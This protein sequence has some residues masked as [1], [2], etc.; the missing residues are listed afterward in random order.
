M[1]SVSIYRNHEGNITG[2]NCIGHA[3]YAESGMDIICAGVSVLVIN[4]I[5][6]IENFT[7]IK[8]SLGT[9][10]ES[11]LIDFKLTEAITDDVKLLIDS[12]I[13]GL[14]GIQNDYGNEY[15][16]LDFKEV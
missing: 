10:E 14:Q 15:I 1:I 7:D 16:V 4:C 11:G 12:M 2:F 5:N 9:D 13:L 3:G 8:F 6:S